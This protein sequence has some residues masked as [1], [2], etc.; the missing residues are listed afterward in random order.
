MRDRDFPCSGA[1]GMDQAAPHC[2][3]DQARRV[4]DVELLHQ[5]RAMGFGG[6]QADAEARGNL[7]GLLPSAIRCSTSRSRA[8]SGS[9]SS[10]FF[11]W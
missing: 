2:I 7:L 10:V 3:E 1:S 8:V 6:L 4:M 5:V 11:L 9:T